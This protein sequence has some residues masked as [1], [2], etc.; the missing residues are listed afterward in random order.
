MEGKHGFF[1]RLSIAARLNVI[2]VL[3]LVTL[4]AATITFLASYLSGIFIENGKETIRMVSKQALMTVDTLAKSL[5]VQINRNLS[6][7]SMSLTRG[8][9]M[10]ELRPGW[11]L[12]YLR[13]RCCSMASFSMA[14]RNMLMSTPK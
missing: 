6:L 4:F 12:A 1:K 8:E 14:R 13:R 10:A 9:G 2:T 3:A 7:F 11:Y 5:E